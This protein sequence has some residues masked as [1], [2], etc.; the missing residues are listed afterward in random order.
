MSL[1]T[2]ANRVISIKYSAL[3]YHRSLVFKWGDD[4]E[5]RYPNST[6]ILMNGYRMTA[7]SGVSFI[8]Q[9]PL[10]FT[11]GSSILINFNLQDILLFGI[12]TVFTLLG[13]GRVED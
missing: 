7:I 3:H 4:I 11:N 2:A 6:K 10:R 8:S 9:M 12:L 13:I 5:D 1:K